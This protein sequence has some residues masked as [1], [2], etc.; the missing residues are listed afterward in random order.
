MNS[1]RISDQT[2]LL[3]ILDAAANRAREGLRVIEDWARFALD[4]AHLTGC[5]KQIRHDLAAVVADIPWEQRLAARE[6]QAD[7]GI[8]PLYATQGHP[9]DAGPL[10]DLGSGATLVPA[11][12]SELQPQNAGCIGGLGE[13]LTCHVLCPFWILRYPQ[14]SLRIANYPSQWSA[15]A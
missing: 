6:T 9:C 2:A 15:L 5:L 10:S 13:I 14:R 7:V 4:D 3:R 8:P 12:G 1:Q 11:R